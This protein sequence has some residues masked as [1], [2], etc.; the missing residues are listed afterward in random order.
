MRLATSSASALRRIAELLAAA[1]LC[2]C[3]GDSQLPEPGSFAVDEQALSCGAGCG[4]QLGSATLPGPAGTVT[5]TAWSNSPQLGTSNDCDPTPRAGTSPVPAPNGP[6][7]YRCP[8]QC[9][10]LRKRYFQGT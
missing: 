3:G 10:G 6:L 4:G 9:V 8:S 2:C 7:S 1:G 5:L